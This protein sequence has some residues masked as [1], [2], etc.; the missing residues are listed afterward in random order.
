MLFDGAA[1]AIVDKATDTRSG[2][3]DTALAITNL[4]ITDAENDN[5]T[6]TLTAQHGK[7]TVN[8]PGSLQIG[9]NGSAAVTLKGSLSDINAALNGMTFLGD[10][11]YN[12]A[13]SFTLQT[14][15][16]ASNASS[17]INLNL[18]PVNDAPTFTGTATPP[19][20]SEGGS[21]QF[22]APVDAGKGFT[23][24]QLGLTDVDN[25]QQQVI[26]KITTVAAHGILTLN[27]NQLTA[28][29]TFSAADLG[30]LKYTHDGS[31]VTTP[32]GITDGFNVNIDDGAGGLLSNQRIDIKVLPV[33]QLPT[34]T[35]Q[36]TVIEGEQ[37]VSLTNNG[38]LVPGV[39]N[40]SR[41]MINVA[42][43]DQTAGFNYRLASLPTHGKLY[44]DG[45]EITDSN[46]VI[47]DLTKLTYSHD[48]TEPTYSTDS[49]QLLVTDDG[50]GTGTPGSTTATI[51]L[52]ILPN[53]N[54]PVLAHHDTQ[55]L[56]NTAPLVVTSGMLQVTDSDSLDSTITYT[57]TGVP[58][59]QY[60][61][62][63]R[64]ANRLDVGSTFTQ[65]DINSGLISYV[66]RQSSASQRTDTLTFTVKDGDV[67]YY[68]TVRDG[69]IYTDATGT[70]LQDNT[71]SVIVPPSLGAGGTLPAVPPASTG[72]IFTGSGHITVEE[73]N[74]PAISAVTLTSTELDVT[75]N[76][77][78]VTDANLTYRL[79]TVPSGGV[80]LLN[81]KILNQYDSFTQDDINNNRVQF[82]DSGGE[83]FIQ[84]FQFTISDGDKVTATQNF[85]ISVTPKN[86]T[87]VASLGSQ[88][89]AVT[90]GGTVVID[91]R[92]IVL[93]D[94]DSQG[95][96]PDGSTQYADTNALT[97]TI[98]GN[99]AHGK[100]FLNGVQI[101]VGAVVTAAELATGKLTYV[102]DGSENYSDFFTLKPHDDQGVGA[103]SGNNQSSDGALLQ[104]NIIINPVNDAPVYDSKVE[105]TGANALYEGGSVVIH[106]DSS[107][108]AVYLKYTDTDNSDV[109]RQYRITA[110]P[111]HGRLMR[112]GVVLGIGSVFTQAELDSGVVS[113]VHDGSDTRSDTFEYVVSDGDWSS[114]ETQHAQQGD[115][116]IT[117]AVFH[118]Q[119]KPVN[120][121]P[122][123]TGPTTPVKVGGDT[124]AE[125]P[126]GGFSVSDPDLSVGDATDFFQVTVR[127]LDGSGNALGAANYTTGG[128]I[129]LSIDGAS[130][131]TTLGHNG[132]GDYLVF[133]GTRAQVNAALASL[134]VLFPDQRNGQ[135]KLQVIV[136]DRSRDAGGVLSGGTANGGD[137]N[138]PTTLGGTP[139]S[140][141]TDAVDGYATAIPATLVGNVSA[142]SVALLVSQSDEAP[143]LALPGPVT[144]PEDVPT[145]IGGGFTVADPESTALDLPVSVTLSVAGGFGTLGVG[146]GGAQTSFTINGRTVTI[147]GDNTGSMTLTG[148]ADDIQDLLNNGTS[149]LTYTSAANDNADH[150]GAAAGD[151][152]VNVSLNEGAAAVGENT[153]GN[154]APSGTIAVTLDATNDA[155]TVS[156]G[157]G[158]I[159]AGQA[160]TEYA[161]GGVSV[162]DQDVPDGTTTDPGETSFVQVTVR[163]L[164]Q[165]G[166]PLGSAAYAGITLDSADTTGAVQIVNSQNGDGQALVIQGDIAAVNAYLAQL[167]IKFDT[168]V[169]NVDKAYKIDVI[170]DDRLRDASGALAGTG[171][172]N[173]GLNLNGAGTGTSA[174]PTTAVDPYAA[175][176][177]GLAS[178]VA[179]AT[180]DLFVSG[181]NDPAEIAASNIVT[182]EN[183]GVVTIP[184]GA[185]TVTD[186]DS[187]A[188]DGS[189]GSNLSA[190]ITVS[191]GTITSAGA[192]ALGGTVTGLGTNTI[193][194]DGVTLAQLNARIAALQITTPGT[195]GPGGSV[196]WNGNFTLS[197]TV[198]DGG[199]SGQR[200]T[201]LPGDTNNANANPGDYSYKDGTSAELLTQ[202]VINVTVNP[203]NDAPTR[204]DGTPV[205]LPAVAEDAGTT[206]PGAT[207]D[208]LFGAKFQDSRDDVANGSSHNNFAGIAITSNGATAAQGAWQYS[209]DGGTTWQAIP[210]V[211]VNNAL[212]LATTDMLRFVPAA[213]YAGA[214]GN[215]DA[216]L[217]DTS[218]TFTH[219]Q[220]VDLSG[221]NSGGTTR[222]S[223]AANS[224]TLTTSVTAVNDAPTLSGPGGITTRED[225]DPAANTGSTVDTIVGGMYS[226]GRDNQSGIAGG[227]DTSTA[228]QGIVILGNTADTATQG[229]WQYS[230]APGVWV[231]VPVGADLGTG[232]TAIYLPKDASLRFQPVA[233]YHGAPPAL[234]ISAVDGSGGARTVVQ[235]GLTITSTGG[236]TA[237]SA[238]STIT[239]DVT[240]VN[241]APD[242]SG[243]DSGTPVAVKGGG[244][245]RL[246]ADGNVS[247]HDID[248]DVPGGNWQGVTLTIA[249]QGGANGNDVFGWATGSGLTVSGTTLLLNGSAIGTI[250]GGTGTLTVTF[251]NTVDAATVGMV[252]GAATYRSTDSATTAS[253]NVDIDFTLNDQD[254][255]ASG[256][257]TA[258]SGQDQGEGGRLLAVHT[259]SVQI[260]TPPVA[261]ALP[262]KTGQDHG[263]V[264]IDT[265]GG[266]T[267]P[268]SGDTYTYTVG[269]LP[270]SL[271]ID[272]AT[273]RI[274]GTLGHSDSQGGT[275]GVYTVTVTATDSH[276]GAT[277]QTFTLTVT[278]PGPAA[279]NDSGAT[280]PATPVSGNVIAGPDAGQRDSD[281]DGDTL[282]VSEVGGS[283]AGVNQPV[284]GSNGGSFVIHSDGSYTFNPGTDFAD[285][286]EGQS[287]TTSVAYQVSDG[288]GGTAT[289][290]L[291]ITVTGINL[292]PVAR[293]DHQQTDA[294]TPTAGNAI[295]PGDPTQADADPEGEAVTVLAVN[296]DTA[297]VGQTVTGSHGGQ[298]LLNADGSYTFDPDGDFASLAQGQSATTQISYEIVD[299]HGHTAT[300]TITV[301]VVG[302]NEAPTAAGAL[303]D[304][305]DVD[306]Q[307]G[308]AVDVS[309]A[310]QDVDGD[311]L[312]YAATG[313]PPGLTID[314][315]TGVIGGTI[316]HSASHGGT[317]GRYTVTITATDSHG[318]AVAR[319]FTWQVVNPAPQADPDT[320]MTRGN[321]PLTGD[322][323]PNDH[324]PD[325][326]AL[327]VQQFTVA[328]TPGT[329]A[330]GD[331]ATIANVGTLTLNRDGTYTFV[332][333]DGYTGDVPLVNYH[334]SDGEGGTADSTLQIVVTRA[335]DVPPQPPQS[336]SWQTLVDTPAG[337]TVA[338]TLQTLRYGEAGDGGADLDDSETGG[339]LHVE[340]WVIRPEVIRISRGPTPALFVTH[341]V[342]ESQLAAVQP[343][344]PAQIES[345]TLVE[346]LAMPYDLHV[347]RA[348]DASQ[349]QT[350]ATELALSAHRVDDS[351][352]ANPLF[353]D[354][355]PLSHLGHEA[356]IAAPRGAAQPGAGRDHAPSF[357]QQLHRAAGAARP[358]SAAT[359]A[360]PTPSRH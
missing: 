236:G 6:V 155:P 285:L 17:T 294:L 99:V 254:S 280:N 273:G 266:F 213:D 52:Q 301:T 125:N 53:D 132:N 10:A 98:E 242:F 193:T 349:R 275:G 325:G 255:N 216:R 2:K 291:T 41:G 226:D 261:A 58:D 167:R 308:I 199:N 42:D 307:G 246:D 164:D 196:D 57:V 134:E 303:P 105:A 4:S 77:S 75:D 76:N 183:N 264:S 84:S 227:T 300:T 152:T 243:L 22:T 60:G 117:P 272:S 14:N 151:V 129:L 331:T 145:F 323:L 114:T 160:N 95:D 166:N 18:S 148:R 207:V 5:Q 36:I 239:A 31:Q 311:R 253:A 142:A 214:P 224:V 127:L 140:I 220:F 267:D 288:E 209:T 72:P 163:L 306:S 149:G 62:F 123:V 12:G 217:V 86:D 186:S 334:V 268:D 107:E 324:D 335:G 38:I 162:T 181:V 50:G 195:D 35:G 102:H 283:A 326:D 28:G 16:G 89:P 184:A 289:A 232:G 237:Y 48:G 188:S 20:V 281:P 65:Q 150:N 205:S 55:T 71:F 336:L 46:F 260:D 245:V 74:N 190:T 279:Q 278:N 233:D 341:A 274:T 297:K 23:D 180:R 229:V 170:A 37:N 33:N 135:Y 146:G 153:G 118:F 165:N 175:I 257:G 353:N 133:Q 269:G 247:A 126:V 13:A 81:G 321:T 115:P 338:M 156:A 78:T 228:F 30:N 161:I 39:I 157:T 3:E 315:G 34:V 94:S 44:Y 204:T 359:P 82:L 176:P 49:F 27:G 298:F 360:S 295:A 221:T 109:Q 250:A 47:A 61:Y 347:L 1:P 93:T 251:N 88:T 63:M 130:G 290:T 24:A 8:T 339:V 259:V 223:D 238:A 230:T 286:D 144:A 277:S 329:Y 43:P 262:D 252:I 137:A 256:G 357:T 64:G 355:D 185:I 136:D 358:Q 313:L 194:V 189:P 7:L 25:S 332:A 328:G 120:D 87:P 322:V 192:L 354:F 173:G 56:T 235:T 100:L 131:V 19:T 304:R 91:N 73:G 21:V 270:P 299:G 40:T 314:S 263:G 9:N 318:V 333:A 138:Q 113:Y 169:A 305:S 327:T 121:A 330:A 111:T 158:T 112:D 168:T 337:G 215:L 172:A 219:G 154:Y 293:P 350:A 97:F 302:T 143:T 59:S 92:Y 68:P 206:P 312:D 222:F 179:H 356:G 124:S 139:T 202:R 69:G 244:A 211:S 103:T 287:R 159:V 258:G 319:T 342:R 29:S 45:T 225:V 348:V 351:P 79:L 200:P 352:G 201:S 316:D 96:L 296:G 67:R 119:I 248:L 26:F 231:D 177:V 249:R 122:V 70:T 310:F 234:T 104:V 174:V 51:G 80:L 343:Y 90:E 340:Y 345:Q 276:G 203:V 54:D 284:A 271:S 11:D 83:D 101:G 218:S 110:A 317:D 208:T 106:G 309:H 141:P 198:N 178:D 346:R 240:P 66:T 191:K 292:P 147:A 212:L 171:L 32:G 241:D 265:S 128:S 15:D 116:A 320:G 344:D 85:S 182:S 282:A 197:V 210:A 187:I 108:G